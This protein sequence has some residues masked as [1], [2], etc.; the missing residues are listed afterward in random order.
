MRN[1]WGGRKGSFNFKYFI[2]R[3]YERINL[4]YIK[5]VT[6]KQD[7]ITEEKTIEDVDYTEM[8]GVWDMD[9]TVQFR[10]KQPPAF[11]FAPGESYTFTTCSTSGA[12][13]PSL[14][15]AQS[16]YSGAS[17]VNDGNKFGVTSGIQYI[18]IAPGTYN[19]T[20][21][22]S[23]G[24]P[25]GYSSGTSTGGD[26]A[27]I[28]G[29]YVA[30]EE[31]VLALLVGQLAVPNDRRSFILNPTTNATT[32]NSLNMFSGGGGASFVAKVN[33]MGSLSNAVPLVVAGAGGSTRTNSSGTLAP[34]SYAHATGFV[35]PNSNGATGAIVASY[36]SG[37]GGKVTIQTRAGSSGAGWYSDGDVG[38]LV[39]TN[40]GSGSFAQ[41]LVSGGRGA[42]CSTFPYGSGLPVGGFGGGGFG[43]WGGSGGGGGWCGG[44]G[45][46]NSAGQGGSGGA[47]YVDPSLTSVNATIGHRGE[48]KIT[49]ARVS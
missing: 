20:A 28:S 42:T 11:V 9:S 10:K 49:I 46:W 16:E 29:T 18:R 32:T 3:F 35:S 40:Y 38:K 41:A 15:D 48:G 33:S 23:V 39:Y 37:D 21:Y 24:T 6:T 2:Q 19:I 30:T 43:G 12:T 44:P 27:Q 45:H 14:S 7:F 36:S 34:P 25:Q 13:G 1:R 26:G 17:W 47:S 4:S 31:Q 5:T 8:S 22:G